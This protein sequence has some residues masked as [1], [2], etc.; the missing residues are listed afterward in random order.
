MSKS[1]FLDLIRDQNTKYRYQKL[2]LRHLGRNHILLTQHPEAGHKCYRV[3]ETH[4]VRELSTQISKTLA[5][6]QETVKRTENSRK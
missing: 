2:Y 6:G 5:S 1:K 4:G 3:V